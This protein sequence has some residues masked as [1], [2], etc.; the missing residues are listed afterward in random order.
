[1]PRVRSPVPKTSSRMARFNAS[2]SLSGLGR[3]RLLTRGAYARYRVCDHDVEGVAPP[4]G[5][6][7]HV[8]VGRLGDHA[9][10]GGVVHQLREEFDG[11]GPCARGAHPSLI[12]GVFEGIRER[13]ASSME[14]RHGA[15]GRT[16]SRPCSSGPPSV[17]RTLHIQRLPHCL[18]AR[19]T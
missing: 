8:G 15:A 19:R 17:N 1:M 11:L 18:L 16:R 7:P 14:W 12:E 2:E 13:L 3:S 4:V 9:V 6:V 10:L 5:H